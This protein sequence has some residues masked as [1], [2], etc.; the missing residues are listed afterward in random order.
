MDVSR[1]NKWSNYARNLGNEI[2]SLKTLSMQGS[3]SFEAN[4]HNERKK[5]MMGLPDGSK[6]FRY[7]HD[8]LSNPNYTMYMLIDIHEPDQTALRTR[9]EEI[10]KQE[11]VDGIKSYF[12][13]L[14]AS[15]LRAVGQDPSQTDVSGIV[16]RGIDGLAAGLR[17]FASGLRAFYAGKGGPR[18]NYVIRPGADMNGN[19]LASNYRSWVEEETGIPVVSTKRVGGIYLYMPTGFETSYGIDYEDSNMAGMDM[20]KM[21]TALMDK[22]VD[23]LVSGEISRKLG[24]ANLKLLN[25]AAELVPGF[26]GDFSKFVSAQ[27]RQVVNPMSLHLFKEV[28]RREFTFPYTFL[29]TNYEEVKNIHA[30]I[31]AL[32]Y[33]A[34]PERSQYGRFL[35]YPA[36]FKIWFR[37]TNGSD[38]YWLPSI[39]KCVLKNIKVKYGDDASFS[40]FE[41]NPGRGSP[42][43]KI[44][45]ELTF[46]ELEILTRERFA[47]PTTSDGLEG[48]TWGA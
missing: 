15:G 20:L 36:E 33:Y 27:N 29:P 4:L 10:V 47:E 40:V 26:E 35:D 44:T 46:G 13:D 12:R 14:A 43:T 45:L 25:K 1:L 22:E 31:N 6:I 19:P 37:E 38:N 41:R 39:Q 34:H 8:L 21:G 48:R 18:S 23:P 42:P 7:P 32:K 3:S 2:E 5:N 28:K 9:R 16:D 24:F 30:I 17:P 11:T